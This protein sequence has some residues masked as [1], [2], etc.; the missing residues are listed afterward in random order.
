MDSFSTQFIS[1]LREGDLEALRSVPKT[2]LHCHG[3][4]SMRRSSLEAWA[5][6]SIP[7]PPKVYPTFTEFIGYVKTYIHPHTDFREGF[8]FCLR[9]ALQEAVSEGIQYVEMSLDLK[10]LEFYESNAAFIEIVRY[11]QKEFEGRIHFGPEIGVK[12][13]LEA[14]DIADIVAELIDSEVFTSIDLYDDELSGHIEDFKSIFDYARRK[15]LKL[16]A[17]S[18]EYAD[19]GSIAHTVELLELDAIQH[20]INCVQD[21]GVMNMLRDSKIPVHVCPT[22]NVAL[23]RVD[24]IRNHPIRRMFDHGILVTVNSDDITLFDQSVTDE[25]VELYGK[26]IFSA[27]ELDQIRLNGILQENV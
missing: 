22:S 19:A 25:F 26:K 27:T 8:E 16:K 14:S 13:T 7:P 4:L 10:F 11:I 23:Q 21:E 24:S 1:G 2:D 6:V 9:A 3:S 18:G 12:R 5:D 17:H 20:G 15:G